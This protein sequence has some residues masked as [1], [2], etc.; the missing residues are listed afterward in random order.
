MPHGYETRC[1]CHY[2]DAAVSWYKGP[3]CQVSRGTW[4][5]DVDCVYLGVHTP[6][7]GQGLRWLMAWRLT[8]RLFPRSLLVYSPDPAFL[9]IGVLIGS[10]ST[11]GNNQQ[12]LRG[13]FF[14]LSTQESLQ[15]FG[16][17]VVPW[18]GPVLQLFEPCPG[19]WT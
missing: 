12:K 3:G 4:V 13:C 1:P 8:L 18:L 19:P 2:P 16:D 17:Q 10:Y 7:F 5:P 9:F 11:A 14:W 6:I 15:V